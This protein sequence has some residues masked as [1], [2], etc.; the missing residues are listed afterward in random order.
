MIKRCSGSVTASHR[1]NRNR[2]SNFYATAHGCLRIREQI[3]VKLTLSYR[4]MTLSV[5][6]LMTHILNSFQY[7]SNGSIFCRHIKIALFSKNWGFIAEDSFDTSSFYAQKTRNFAQHA[8]L[9]K[10]RDSLQFWSDLDVIKYYGIS[11]ACESNQEN[12][13]TFGCM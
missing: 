9:N 5:A 13:I 7:W 3:C 10:E 2:I 1:Q 11:L 8:V 4:I 6:N 12:W